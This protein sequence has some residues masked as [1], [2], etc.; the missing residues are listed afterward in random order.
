ML[1]GGNML[2]DSSDNLS[3]LLRVEDNGENV[4]V[5]KNTRIDTMATG[6]GDFRFT[7]EDMEIGTFGSAT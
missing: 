3:P 1:K 4:E 6:V 5:K 7:E 2:L